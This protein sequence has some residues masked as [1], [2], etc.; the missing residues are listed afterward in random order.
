[1]QKST[2]YFLELNCLKDTFAVSYELYCWTFLNS[3]IHS[4]SECNS[5]AF[6][7]NSRNILKNLKTIVIFKLFDE[8]WKNC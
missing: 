7:K 3:S 6:A 8:T 4:V 2:A 1:M 5:S